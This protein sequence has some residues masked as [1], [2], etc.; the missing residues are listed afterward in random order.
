MPQMP[1]FGTR[2]AELR[3][4]AELNPAFKPPKASFAIYMSTI[5]WEKSP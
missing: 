1:G 4:L 3:Q 5:P 2:E